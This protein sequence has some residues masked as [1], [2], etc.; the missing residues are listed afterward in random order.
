MDKIKVSILVPAYN[1]ES[2]LDECLQSLL[3]QTLKEVEIVVV[4]DGSSDRTATIA[5]QYAASDSRIRII[6]LPEHQGVSHARNACLAEAQGEYLSFVDSDDTISST[7]MEELYHKAKTTDVDIALGSMLYCYPDGRQVRVGDKSPV[8]RSDNE[9]LSGQEC[10]IRMQQTGCYVPMVCSNLY[11]TAFIK[12]HPQLHFEGEFHEDEYFTPFALYEATRVTDFKKDFYH[13]RQRTES[14]MHSCKNIKQRAE[15]LC[16]VSKE[17]KTFSKEH[18]EKMDNVLRVAFEQYSELLSFRSQNLYEQELSHSDKKCLFIFTGVSIAAKFGIGTYI[19]QLVQ[20]FDSAIWDVQ[21][22]TLY[23]TAP[24][25]EFS[26]EK[27]IAW[28]YIPFLNDKILYTESIY[29]EEYNKSIFY[30]LAS[31]IKKGRKTFC[32]FNFFYHKQLAVLFKEQLQAYIVYTLHCTNWSFE[33]LGD[34]ERLK[35][36]L[37]E[38]D[39]ATRRTFEKEKEFMQSCCDKVIAIAQHSY[40]MLIDLYGMHPS[41]VVKIPNAISDDFNGKTN[42]NKKGIR[43]K[44]K[45]TE[46]EKLIIFAGRLEAVKGIMELIDAFK[47]IVELIPE[48]RLIIAG[49]GDFNHCLEKAR[50]YSKYITFT[51]YLSKE[52][53]YELYHI[54]NVG[55]IPSIH[56][57]FGYVAIE[58]MLNKLPVIVHKT[59]GLAEIT[60]NGKYGETFKF[61]KNKEDVSSL[62]EAISKV[63]TDRP[64]ENQ[65]K[66]RRNWVL[67][68]YSIP[69]F[70]RRILNVYACMENPCRN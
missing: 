6:R 61:C 66:E 17:L 4:D 65:L 45:Y 30:Y 47:D 3:S 11:R 29:G 15:S 44:Y 60:D 18:C 9:I 56:E 21:V 64:T 10:F 28:Y 63:L 25:I 39:N 41:K 48:V 42:L 68:N 67:K 27:G 50:P 23:N 53:L 14:I 24:K 38:P 31:R 12:A 49:S 13:Y 8:F 26:I 2:Y 33:L 37:A 57:E 1:V 34:K 59:T 62:T 43:E 70:R 69:L 52:Q 46:N 54:A 16:F 7:A 51:G 55:V 35:S 22:V 5:E 36:L 32:H 58:M 40:E 19:S 20:C